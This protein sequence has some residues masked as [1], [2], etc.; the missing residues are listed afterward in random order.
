[1]TRPGGRVPQ[2]TP[3]LRESRSAGG[4]PVFWLHF[5]G[6]YGMLKPALPNSSGQPSLTRGQLPA[7]C[8]QKKGGLPVSTSEVLQ[9]CLGVV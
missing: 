4:S 3:S 9:L 6:W 5:V 1:M 8:F 7:L 2:F